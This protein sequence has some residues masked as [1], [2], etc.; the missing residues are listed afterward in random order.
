[1]PGRNARNWC[2]TINNYT[3]L[4]QFDPDSMC[5]LTFGRE[6]APSTGT[7]HLQ[8]YVQFNSRQYLTYLRS[9]ISD[10]GR[11]TIAEG[12]PE[13]NRRYCQKD[14]DFEEFGEL[15]TRG[16]KKLGWKSAKKSSN[17]TRT[18]RTSAR[19]WTNAPT[20]LGISNCCK[21]GGF[22]RVLRSRMFSICMERLDVAK[23]H[24]P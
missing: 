24:Q 6:V 1:M 11:Y 19:C 15:R 5:Y 7:P 8:G 21:R 10:R 2:F 17:N 14:G 16:K 12:S 22:E 3:D 23:L 9:V 4:P 13:D 18:R 20:M